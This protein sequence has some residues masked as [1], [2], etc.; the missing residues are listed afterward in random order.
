ME[1]F[2]VYIGISWVVRGGDEEEKDANTGCFI[3]IPKVS[4]RSE[5]N[6]QLLSGQKLIKNDKTK[7]FNIL[8]HF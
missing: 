8:K 2:I 6:L 7:T 4:E 3:N 5:L 1:D